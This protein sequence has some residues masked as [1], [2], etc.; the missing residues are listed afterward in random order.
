MCVQG[1]LVQWSLFPQDPLPFSNV[2]P[3]EEIL[4]IYILEQITMILFFCRLCVH[5]AFSQVRKKAVEQ[6]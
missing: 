2:S 1:M 5:L 4:V 3:I 6:K